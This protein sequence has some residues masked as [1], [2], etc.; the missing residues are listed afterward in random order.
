MKNK[1]L[2]VLEAMDF[3]FVNAVNPPNIMALNPHPA[4]SFGL[5]SRASGASLLGGMLPVCEIVDCYHRDIKEK[6]SNPFFLSTIEKVYEQTFLLCPNGWALEMMLP[7]MDKRQR[8]LN[9]YAHDHHEEL[10]FKSLIDYFLENRGD[11]Y[12]ALLWGFES[13]YPFYSPKGHDR[14][15]ALLFLDEQVKRVMEN[16]SEDHVVLC[17]DHNLP[18]LVV[19]AA[20]DTPA[21]ETMKTFIASNFEKAESWNVDVHKIARERWL[22][23]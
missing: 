11:S 19:S 14:K 7:F 13:H 1:V 6:W 17:S 23:E 10:P 9:F 3:E 5:G 20:R 2:I 16:C 21:P 15:E 12:F 8:E 18:P 4:V 22:N